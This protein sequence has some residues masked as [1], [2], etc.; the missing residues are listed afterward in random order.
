LNKSLLRILYTSKTYGRLSEADLSKLLHQ[1]REYNQLINVHG[2]LCYNHSDFIQV[3]EGPETAVI[4][5]YQKIIDDERHHDCKLIN[6]SLTDK[7]IFKNWSMGY[8]DISHG[9][10]QLLRQELPEKL[11]NDNADKF[12]YQL[13]SYLNKPPQPHTGETIFI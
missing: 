3:L 9:N 11:S 5:L 4:K 7:Y 10:M 13:K 1:C 8:I 6:I 12:A 2:I